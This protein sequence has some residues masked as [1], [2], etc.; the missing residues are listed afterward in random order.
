D[1]IRF[2]HI[3]FCQYFTIS[4]KCRGGTRSILH[5]GP[6]F[7]L[8]ITGNSDD[9]IVGFSNSDEGF[10]MLYRDHIQSIRRYQEWISATECEPKLGRGSCIDDTQSQFFT[11]LEI[12]IRGGLLPIHEKSRI[13]DVRY[14]CSFHSLSPKI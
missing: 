13:I 4:Q 7:Q 8:A 14:I 5:S 3:W 6:E 11:N 10:I 1:L 9:E 2:W 12:R